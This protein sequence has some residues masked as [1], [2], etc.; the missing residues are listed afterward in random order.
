MISFLRNS[1]SVNQQRPSFS[2][3][4]N[5]KN[6][7]IGVC[8]FCCDNLYSEAFKI[9]DCFIILFCLLESNKIRDGLKILVT[10]LVV[11]PFNLEN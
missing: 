8:Q 4:S 10:N 3:I 5:Y 2:V 9:Y 6:N 11:S 1:L 7:K